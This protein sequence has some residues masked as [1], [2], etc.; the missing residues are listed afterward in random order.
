MCHV[1]NVLYI[2]FVVRVLVAI[3]STLKFPAKRIQT[4]GKIRTTLLANEL[5]DANTRSK[6]HAGYFLWRGLELSRT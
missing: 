6:I 4:T 3:F 1:S 5:L 2:F